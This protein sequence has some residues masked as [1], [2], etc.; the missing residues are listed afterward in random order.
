MSL[1]LEDSD[2]SCLQNQQHGCGSQ[3]IHSGN[4]SGV[5]ALPFQT[6]LC[7]D[8]FPPGLACPIC[9]FGTSLVVS[10]SIYYLD[11]KPPL[12]FPVTSLLWRR[13]S[14]FGTE[15]GVLA[16]GPLAAPSTCGT[17]NFIG[18]MRASVFSPRGVFYM[19]YILAALFL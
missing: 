11:I 9:W 5:R 15:E 4:P 13:A 14:C 8:V 16:V 3:N 7:V 17:Y 19:V 12:S 10:A 18:K 1:I 6:E 2:G